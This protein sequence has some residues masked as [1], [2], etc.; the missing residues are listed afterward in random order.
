L[1]HHFEIIIYNRP[2]HV[3]GLPLKTPLTVFSG[4]P[5]RVIW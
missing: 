4:V 1:R 3:H 5:T 2:P